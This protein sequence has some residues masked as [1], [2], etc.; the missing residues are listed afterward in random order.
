MIAKKRTLCLYNMLTM[1]NQ[2][3]QILSIYYINSYNQS[4]Q[5]KKMSY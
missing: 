3:L 2:L 4:I 1:Q 5:Q